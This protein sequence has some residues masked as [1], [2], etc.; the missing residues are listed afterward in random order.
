MAGTCSRELKLLTRFRLGV[1][2]PRVNASGP[3]PASPPKKIRR[4]DAPLS[5]VTSEVCSRDSL[6]NP[7][8]CFPQAFHRRP[9]PPP[10]PSIHP[11]ARGSVETG[12]S[13]TPGSQKTRS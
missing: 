7:L 1:L 9:R 5:N 10:V 12:N 8:V 6:P 13:T 11:S 2:R 4:V 3:P